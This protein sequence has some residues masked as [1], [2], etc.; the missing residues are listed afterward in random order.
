[1]S[2]GKSSSSTDTQTSQSTVASDVSGVIGGDVF[3]G[4]FE[5][6]GD[7]TPAVADAFQGLI[8]LAN[9]T[10]QGAGDRASG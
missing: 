3:Q 7:F 1:M 8:N 6:S 9:S 10:I 5:I 4:D 2:G